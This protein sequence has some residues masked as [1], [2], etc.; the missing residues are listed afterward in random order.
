MTK[1]LLAVLLA[2]LIVVG[3]LPVAGA[4]GAG[5]EFSDMPD[6][7]STVALKSAVANGLLIGDNGKIM[8]ENPLTRAQMATII[9]RAFG[10]TEEGD[11]S[12]YTDVKS[13][14]WFA[15]SI[16]KAYKMGVMEG[17]AGK[18]NPDNNITREQAF[19]VLA[20]ALKLEPASKC[21][22]T[23]EDISNV[24][25]WATGEVY[26]MV[27]A[28]Y[29]QG[30]NGKLNPQSNIRRNEFAQVMYNLMQQYIVQEGE[31][32][33]AAEGNVMVNV[34]GVTLKGLTVKGD[35]II[36]DG[37][38]DGN[39]ILD[40][41]VVTGRLVI[42]GGGKNSIIICGSSDVSNV[43]A[44]RV[45][46]AVR[47]KVEGNAKVE[48]IYVDDGSDDIIIVGSVG[49]VEVAADNI[50]VTA[51]G[52]NI[53]SANIS[54]SGSALIV[55]SSSKVDS[56]SV[57]A[58]NAEVN[59]EG[60]VNNITTSAANT[61][62]TGK[63][64]VNKVEV[65]QGADGA[66]IETPKTEITVSE[67]V[68]DVTA[69]G[70]TKVEGGS[71]VTNN[72]NGTGVEEPS[73]GGGGGGGGGSSTT[74]V[75]AISVDPKMMT[76]TVGE[77][78]TITA[79]VSPDYATNK[80][81]NW[82]SS[83]ESVA[84]VDDKGNVTAVA[85]G[86]ATI[87]ATS[88]A[89]SS[90]KASCEVTVAIAGTFESTGSVGIAPESA[91]EAA[92][93][94]YAEYKLVAGE[95]ENAQDISLAEGNVDYIKVKVGD[96]AWETLTA[97]TDATLWFNVEAD[98]GTRAYEVKAK[99]GN[100]YTATLNW[101]KEIK[102][103][104]WEATDREGEHDGK[105]Y[106]EYKMMDGEGQV[107]LKEGKVKLIASEKEGKW[108][109]LEPNTDA[110]LWFNKAKATGNYDFF[111]VTSEG[112]MYKATLNWVNPDEEAAALDA[113]NKATSANNYAEVRTALETNSTKLGLDLTDYNKLTPDGRK[114]AVAND[115]YNNKP[116][117]GYTLETLKPTF[118]EIVA[119]RMVFQESV[120]LFAGASAD[121]P[122][123]DLSYITMLQENLN[124]VTLQKVHSGKS[125]KE[126]ILPELN[127][128]V[129]DFNAL[130]TE[131]KAAVLAGIDYSKSASSTTT[132]NALRAAITKVVADEE[133][134]AA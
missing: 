71:T 70:G 48:T 29:I 113:V 1:R 6:N 55:D 106:V 56:V 13:T 123:T 128:L 121:K 99:D 117:G 35:L 24:S 91:G 54:G 37:V 65:Q 87:I 31:Y 28:G 80:K 5:S 134:A 58:T 77:T 109:A 100:V 76:L 18:M 124:A 21:N 10:A 118:D 88:D 79:I 125:I 3:C 67:G 59:V 51:T 68:S 16:A 23:F 119:T 73:T 129:T 104:T 62:V 122:L 64:S 112:T 83:D 96:G 26:A 30:A 92:G 34:P 50:T 57:T 8:P 32:T 130:T 46:G 114:N 7:W 102:T 84:T 78:G 63:G 97:N 4:T 81:V 66:K 38:G 36:G 61:N 9:V 44:T 107:S 11:I 42:R 39:V 60:S 75:T 27:N 85:S 47:V 93:K 14:D 43:I 116:E 33:E 53:D 20:R 94:I 105:T 108:V 22:K 111:V 90:K 131:Q 103:A 95:G 86:K 45:D 40:D 2:L 115:I 110:T 127:G 89:D 19:A 126:V 72:G 41:V 49:S 17:Y 98:Q 15:S 82:S 52:A 101:D 12:A 74:E 25:E 132:R 133:A 69:G 120:A